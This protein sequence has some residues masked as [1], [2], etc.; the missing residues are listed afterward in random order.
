MRNL[1]VT[2][3]TISTLNV[4]WEPAEGSVRE[5]IVIYVPA[6]S[7]DQEVVRMISMDGSEIAKGKQKR[8]FNAVVSHW[9][10]FTLNIDFLIIVL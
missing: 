8:E 9:Y 2:D 6:G 1:Q 5:Y 4:R 3:P 10:T 7:Q